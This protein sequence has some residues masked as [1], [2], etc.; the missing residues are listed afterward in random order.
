MRQNHGEK[1]HPGP[2]EGPPEGAPEGPTRGAHPAC[3]SAP[4]PEAQAGPARPKPGLA[5]SQPGPG[6]ISGDLES[7]EL[8]IQRNVEKNIKIQMISHLI[9][10]LSADAAKVFFT[11]LIIVMLLMEPSIFSTLFSLCRATGLT[12]PK[13]PNMFCRASKK[14]AQESGA[15][16]C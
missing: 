5:R 3:L 15:R 1:N 12:N 11:F 8:V 9:Q 2:P 7:W 14:L 13:I 10:L 4:R 6:Q 16:M